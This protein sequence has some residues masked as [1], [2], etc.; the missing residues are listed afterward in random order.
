M[1][2]REGS[3]KI[4][5]IGFDLGATY[6]FDLPL[7]PSVAVGYAFGTGTADPKGLVDKSFRQTGLQENEDRFHGVTSFKYYGELFD[8]ELSNL[9]IFT[10]GIGIRPTR[11]SSIDLVYHYYIIASTRPRKR[12]ET[13]RSTPIPRASA[14]NWEVRSISS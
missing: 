1:R 10:G 3:K 11:N 2:G 8:P 14:K 7:K 4:R 13:R 6:Q 5:G 9:M 12:F